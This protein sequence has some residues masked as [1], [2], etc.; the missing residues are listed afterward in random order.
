MGSYADLLAGLMWL[1]IG[2]LLPFS[3]KLLLEATTETHKKFW[4][5]LGIPPGSERVNRIFVR[6]VVIIVGAVCILLG[7]GN[8]YEFF[9]GREWPLRNARWTDLWPF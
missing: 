9:T 1:I 6:S 4:G 3:W 2:L 5:R 8:L 7:I